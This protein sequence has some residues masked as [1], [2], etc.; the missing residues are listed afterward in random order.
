MLVLILGTWQVLVRGALVDRDED[1]GVAL[2]DAA[3]PRALAEALADVGN[4]EVALPLLAV[5][6]ALSLLRSR[7][8]TWWPVLCYALATGLLAPLVS[9]VKAWT[10]RTGP[11]GGGGFYPSGH[12][13]IT[14]AALGAALLLV[15]CGLSRAARSSAYVVVAVLVLGNGLG[16]VWRGYH[17]PLDVV[18]GWCLSVLLLCAAFAAS[19]RGPGRLSS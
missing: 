12:A 17:W 6:M 2:R 15:H 11:L 7:G 8:R 9:A 1:L 10:D 16:L 19:G 13:T 3:P 4:L 18:A 14:A 5:A